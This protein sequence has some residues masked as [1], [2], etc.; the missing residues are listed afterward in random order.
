MPFLGTRGANSARGFGFAGKNI[1]PPGL[2]TNFSAA[3]VAQLNGALEST[4]TFTPP[5]DNGGGNILYYQVHNTSSNIIT[6]ITASGQ[7]VPVLAN[8][9]YQNY[10]I[11]AVNSAGPGDWTSTDSA[12]CGYLQANGYGSINSLG[13]TINIPVGATVTYKLYSSSGSSSKPDTRTYGYQ[14]WMNVYNWFDEIGSG[15]GA[16]WLNGNEHPWVGGLGAEFAGIRDPMELASFNGWSWYGYDPNYVYLYGNYAWQPAFGPPYPGGVYRIVAGNASS[17]FG[18]SAGSTIGSIFQSSSTFQ[19]QV[20]T[21][22]S[23][24][25]GPTTGPTNYLYNY[26]YATIRR[27]IAGGYNNSVSFVEGT[28]TNDSGPQVYYQLGPASNSVYETPYASSAGD[29]IIGWGI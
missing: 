21:G 3:G 28:Y 11:R 18:Y 8:N 23:P 4:I 7:K 5:T 27:Q 9:V 19:Q 6:N 15:F 17:Y 20:Q 16:N 1:L 13:A 14:T 26:N 24:A 10:R 25:E 2:P 12:L 29:L 22:G